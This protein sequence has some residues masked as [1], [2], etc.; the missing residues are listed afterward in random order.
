[1]PEQEQDMFAWEGGAASVP[2]AG[3]LLGAPNAGVLLAP[4]AGVAEAPKAGGVAAPKAGAAGA[5][6]TDMARL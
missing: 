2:K 6:G 5:A 4:K 1:M 3:A